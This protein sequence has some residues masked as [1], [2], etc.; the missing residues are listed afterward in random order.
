MHYLNYAFFL[1]L[2][3]WILSGGYVRYVV[4]LIGSVFTTLESLEE[5]G[6][7]FHRVLA[8]LVKIVLTVAQ[9]YVLGIWSAYCVLR[10]MVFLLEPGTNGWL[11]YISAFIICEG[12]LGIVAKREPYRGL[13]SVF[14][15]AMAMGFFVIFAL[16]PY[17]L[18]SVYPWLP[19]LMKFPIG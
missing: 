14:H 18:A 16:N 12:I 4:P 9:A 17:F 10:T 13:L 11:Y 6:Q 15:S 5:S 19:P 2:W 3:G 1:L 8:F 7:I